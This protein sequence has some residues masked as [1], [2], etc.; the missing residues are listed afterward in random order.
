[1]K[2]M[3]LALMLAIG[4]NVSVQAADNGQGMAASYALEQYVPVKQAMGNL[5]KG[6][7]AGCLVG[8]I[9]GDV[10]N[11]HDLPVLGGAI[12][13]ILGLAYCFAEKN[14]KIM[15]QLKRIV[16]GGFTGYVAA[17]AADRGNTP[18]LTVL[19][20]CIGSM[21]GMAYSIAKPRSA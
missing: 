15:W 13:G 17:L 16:G 2:K 21:L 10:H 14:P 4:A 3:I 20:T 9:T 11:S 18:G 5:A 6:A 19:G 1:M 7:L 8:C 12:G